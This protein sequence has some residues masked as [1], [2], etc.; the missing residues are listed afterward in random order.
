M[1]NENGHPDAGNAQRKI[2][3]AVPM[4]ESADKK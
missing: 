1:K 3:S 2:K 4:R